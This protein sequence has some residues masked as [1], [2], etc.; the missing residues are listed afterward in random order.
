M[1]HWYRRIRVLEISIF[2]SCWNT[3][4]K[5][6]LFVG[7]PVKLITIFQFSHIYLFNPEYFWTQW[8]IVFLFSLS[9]FVQRK[10]AFNFNNFICIDQ[11]YIT[12]L[13]TRGIV[14]S[15]SRSIFFELSRSRRSISHFK[16]IFHKIWRK[17]NREYV[18]VRLKWH[19]EFYL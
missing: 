18:L 3:L 10:Y 6:L 4:L 13:H 8:G 9:N 12:I 7:H 15:N 19:R 2:N 16:T 14:Q 5:Y 17:S 11:F 1:I